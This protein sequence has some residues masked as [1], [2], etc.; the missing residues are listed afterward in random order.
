MGPEPVRSAAWV[1]RMTAWLQA[2]PP[3]LLIAVALVALAAA[4]ALAKDMRAYG[5]ELRQ[6]PAHADVVTLQLAF[7]AE[8]GV[9]GR[10]GRGEIPAPVARCPGRRRVR[11]RCP[12][13]P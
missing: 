2:V 13:A 8:K 11:R 7:S 10:T 5:D 1:M 6:G 9:S 4:F 12:T 3:W